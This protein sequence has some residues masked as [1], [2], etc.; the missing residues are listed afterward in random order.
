MENTWL[1]RSPTD[2]FLWMSLSPQW[3]KL[4][5]SGVKTIE[6]RK[7]APANIEGV[8]FLLYSSSPEKAVLGHGIVSRVHRG[9]WENLAK[10]FQT[11]GVASID[12]LQDYYVSGGV[13]RM[14]V[15]IE[16]RD[17]VRFDTPVPWT[18]LKPLVPGFMPPV[19]PQLATQAKAQAITA[20]LAYLTLHA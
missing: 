4:I 11:Q 7:S 5:A 19:A 14:A 10:R 13:V 18:A 2:P 17:V 15:A 9:P 1:N 8:P 3:A 16:V 20:A 6:W 12:H